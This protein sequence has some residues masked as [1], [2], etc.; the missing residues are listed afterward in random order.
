[1]FCGAGR[2]FCL[3]LG[4]MLL[5]REAAAQD[6]TSR[7]KNYRS[8]YYNIRTD[9][10]D[11]QAKTLAEHMDATFEAYYRLF[12]KLPVRVQRV[13]SLDLYLFVEQNDYQAVLKNQFKVDGTGSKGMCISSGSKISLV[14]WRGGS[15]VESLKT[16][17]QHEGF[18]QV[19][20]FIFP[21]LPRWAEEGLARLF[22]F[23]VLIDGQ[24]VLGEFPVSAKRQL[25]AAMEAQKTLPFDRLFTIDGKQWLHQ[26]NTGDAHPLYYQSWSLVYF[27]LFTEQ[28]KYESNFLMFLTQLNRQGDWQKA[29]VSSFGIPDFRVLETKW[30]DYVRGIPPS[31]YRETVRRMR[32]LSAGLAALHEKGQHPATLDELKEQLVAARFQLRI[33]LFDEARDFSAS[34]ARLFEVP[35]AEDWA[36]RKFVVVPPKAVGGR[37]KPAPTPGTLVAEGLDPLVFSAQWTRTGRDAT[38]VLTAKPKA[39]IRSPGKAGTR[40]TE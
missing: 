7:A 3:V 13:A 18:H 14:A 8:K 9:L 1:M 27:L 19:S 22:E 10:P 20:S 29:F 34:D 23:G 31:D 37:G 17:L 15:S 35:L 39:A 21:G 26:V 40:R 32:F 16:T 5:G 25:I 30:R 24:L 2:L 11:E 33:D 4:L 28:G 36:E 38:Y 12:S 6:W